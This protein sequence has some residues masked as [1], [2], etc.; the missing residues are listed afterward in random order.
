MS[1]APPHPSPRPHGVG[2][3][4]LTLLAGLLVLLA[5]L[6]VVVVLPFIL[7]LTAMGGDGGGGVAWPIYVW[8]PAV[9]L[10]GV[11]T[12]IAGLRVIG[13]PRPRPVLLLIILA[14]AAFMSF[15]PFWLSGS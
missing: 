11:F 12:I 5:G 10:A 9:F 8:V 4:L 13:D 7:V 14:M 3:F 6:T 1:D 2:P 15:P